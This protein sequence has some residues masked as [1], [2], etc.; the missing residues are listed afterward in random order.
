MVGAAKKK[1][2]RPNSD[3]IS[4]TMMRFLLEDRRDRG[5][6]Y[7]VQSTQKCMLVVGTLN[8]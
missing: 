7:K 1:D 3:R 5:G 6:T 4:D 2:P 8:F